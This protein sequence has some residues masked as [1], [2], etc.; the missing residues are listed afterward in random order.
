LT[1]IWWSLAHAIRNDAKERICKDLEQ[2][3]QALAH[4]IRGAIAPA[5]DV[6]VT[7]LEDYEKSNNRIV[8]VVVV[9]AVSSPDFPGSRQQP[10]TDGL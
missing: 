4:A 9:A 6:Q 2:L 7:N 10:F 5:F 3:A 8:G 1:N